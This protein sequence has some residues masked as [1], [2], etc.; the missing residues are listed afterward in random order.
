M[1]SVLISEHSHLRYYQIIQKLSCICLTFGTVKAK[2]DCVY[3]KNKCLFSHVHFRAKS[4]RKMRLYLKITAGLLL[5]VQAFHPASPQYTTDSP[6]KPIHKDWL[7]GLAKNTAESQ[8]TAVPAEETESDQKADGTAMESNN[9]YNSGIAS[10]YMTLTNEEEE[11]LMS[12]DKGNEESDD[13]S[14]ATMTAPPVNQNDTNEQPELQ[15][16]TA[17][18]SGQ[19]NMTEEEEE[20]HRTT[21]T[22]ENIT[23]H[24]SA[25]N[26]SSFSDPSNHTDLQTT[27]LAPQGNGTQESANKPAGD[28]QFT[29]DTESTNSTSLTTTKIPEKNETSTTSSSTTVQSETTE[30]S[31]ETTTTAAANTPGTD[32]NADKGSASGSSSDRGKAAASG[33]TVSVAHFFVQKTALYIFLAA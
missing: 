22:P 1:Q 31:P 15:D 9:E 10:G 14:N 16:T 6:G 27:T 8:N 26:S 21:A 29:N 17:T 32:D 30:T 33:V 19:I 2:M 4:K 23:N 7:R 25:Q 24:L 3:F 18:S 5:L 11:N 20:V 28:T 13:V 12:Q